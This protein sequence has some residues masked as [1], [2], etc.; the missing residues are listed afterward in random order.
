MQRNRLEEIIIGVQ[1]TVANTETTGTPG[2]MGSEIPAS[3]GVPASPL[4]PAST[5]ITGQTSQLKMDISQR[6]SYRRQWRA[7]EVIAMIILDAGLV[8][9]SFLL[10]YYLR[11]KFFFNSP[12]IAKLR[13]SLP[14]L[15]NSATH[16]LTKQDVSTPLSTYS[17]LQIGVTLG[18]IVIFALR[19]LYRIPSMGS[20]FRQA[21]SIVSSAT[22]GLTILI[23]YYF[24]VQ[25]TSNSR[26]LVPFV[27]ITAII[28]LCLFRL[29][30][31][32]IMGILHR[33]GVA[34]TRVLVVGSGRLGKLIMQHMAANPNLGYS[35]VGFLH[36]MHDLNEP[37]SDFGRFKMLGTLED[38]HMVIKS[39]KIDEVIIALPSNLHQQSIR[40]VRLLDR[41]GTS[42]K[43]VPDLYELSLSRIDMEAV[44]GIPLI[45]IKE[46]SLNSMLRIV[47]KVV[48]IT[49]S[50][51]VLLIGLP[52]W[53]CIALAIA[54]T[55]KGPIIYKQARIGLNGRPFQVY[56][57]RTM[58]KDAERALPSLMPY[59]QAQ[60]PLFKIK[61]DPRI[62]PVGKFLRRTSFDEVPQ[63]LNILRGE[64][65]L[66][67]PRPPLPQEVAAYEDWQKG[68]LAMKPG[69][70]GLWQVRGRSD[71][72]FDEGVL[73]DLYYI[74]NWSLSLYFKV[75]L[76]TIPAVLFSRGA[77]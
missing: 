69:L 42:F 16:L 6:R 45:A 59:N 75:L 29:I 7:F 57:F 26:L 13:E 50:I 15:E 40:S 56:K 51:L 64:M 3:P 62:T 37:P 27:W 20:W 71:I 19:G 38:L 53:L 72:S 21:R 5:G 61:D 66:V 55:S 46:A 10:A 70:T 54:L 24:V 68:R 76:R 14:G 52:L 33:L 48:D 1:T 9:F 44:E 47:M 36:D 2:P 11:Y 8:Y 4:S 17:S 39:M 58:Y 60:G 23:A 65:S 77:Y 73:M 49:L 74:Q 30:V 63:F 28:V 35:V 41:L 12:L 31:S 18:L 67:G 25:S 43:L 32:S 22:L 34:E